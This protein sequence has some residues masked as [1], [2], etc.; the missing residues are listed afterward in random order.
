MASVGLL[1]ELVLYVCQL[2]LRLIGVV[3]GLVSRSCIGQNFPIALFIKTQQYEWDDRRSREQ[4]G[5][6][7]DLGFRLP[8]EELSRQKK[9]KRAPRHQ[10]QHLHRKA[11]DTRPGIDAVRQARHHIGRREE[12]R[13]MLHIGRKVTDRNGGAG[14][15]NHRQPEKLVEDLCF[16]HGVGDAGDDESERA[17]GNRADRHE[18]HGGQNIADVMHV[19]NETRAEEFG[20]HHGKC[21]RKI[22][23]NTGCKH[24]GRGYRRNV[25]AA[26]DALFAEHHKSR[27]ESPEAAHHVQRQHRTKVELDL[28]RITFGEDAAIE[29]EKAKRHDYTEEEK[30]FVTQ[31]QAHAGARQ[32][33]QIAQSRSLLP[34]SSMNTSSSEGVAISRLTSSLP[35]ASRCLTNATIACGGARQ[36]STDTAFILRQCPRP[37]RHFRGSLDSGLA[38]RTSMRGLSAGAWFKGRGGRLVMRLPWSTMATRSHNFSA[39][40]M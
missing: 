9:G 29:K 13:S 26:Q 5:I 28:S 19:E 4:F 23:Q 35:C 25:K 27:A 30:H 22:C 11:Q 18:D 34:V 10:R 12:Q 1:G 32:R 7:R 33:S 20:E 15:E 8:A 3:E 2:N 17:E 21:Q 6:P 40:S 37:S 14:K 38:R 39:S 31:C 24:V 16:L 36:C